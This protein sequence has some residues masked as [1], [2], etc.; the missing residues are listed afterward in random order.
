[1]KTFII[2]DAKVKDNAITFINSL[3]LDTPWCITIKKHIKTRTEEQNGLYRRWVRIMSHHTGY[4]EDEMH[5]H[6][7][8]EFLPWHEKD[9][10]GRTV[11][12]LTSTTKLNTKEMG[13]YMDKCDRFAAQELGC[14]LPKLS[15]EWQE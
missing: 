10:F 8:R 6:L 3:P 5:D 13:E 15:D 2:R 11:L 12:I 7:R 9:V 14:V 1:M 4:T